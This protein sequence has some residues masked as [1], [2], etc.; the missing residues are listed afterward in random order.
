MYDRKIV[1]QSIMPLCAVVSYGPS[2]SA[3]L[4]SWYILFISSVVVTGTALQMTIEIFDFNSRD[5]AV[6]VFC[7]GVASAG[8][9]FF[10]ICT[11]YKFFECTKQGGWAEIGCCVPLILVWTIGTASVTRE[12][13]IGPNIVGNNCAGEVERS[14]TRELQEWLDNCTQALANMTFGDEKGTLVV[15]AVCQI[16]S[17]PTSENIPGSNLYFGVWFCLLSSVSIALRWKAQQALQFAQARN[18]RLRE[19]I[20]DKQE[21][22]DNDDDDLSR[23]EDAVDF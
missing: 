14:V 10:W 19:K 9:A 1:C 5:D 23:F 15:D 20:A 11:H 4:R 22:E 21:N 6:M 13:G 18:D 3:T 2:Y 7:F 17:L 16:Q 8:I 12:G